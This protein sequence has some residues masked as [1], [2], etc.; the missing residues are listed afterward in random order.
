MFIYY[1][2]ADAYFIQLTWEGSINVAFVSTLYRLLPTHIAGCDKVFRPVCL[3]SWAYFQ[4][5]GRLLARAQMLWQVSVR[6]LQILLFLNF[7]ILHNKTLK[8]GIW[9][10]PQHRPSNIVV[11]VKHLLGN[12]P[13]TCPLP[14]SLTL[15]ALKQNLQTFFLLLAKSN[16]NATLLL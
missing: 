3:I 5:Y 2:N 9:Y 12:T 14:T 7:H 8:V 4:L 6:L 15:F 13:K 1:A 16:V 11:C 10:F